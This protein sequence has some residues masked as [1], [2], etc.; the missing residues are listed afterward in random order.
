MAVEVILSAVV[1]GR[2]VEES[3]CLSVIPIARARDQSRTTPAAHALPLDSTT[4]R[5]QNQPRSALHTRAR[6]ELATPQC[7]E[8]Q[9]TVPP[10]VQHTRA[11]YCTYTGDETRSPTFGLFYYRSFSCLLRPHNFSRPSFGHISNACTLQTHRVH[12]RASGARA[13]PHAAPRRLSYIPIFVEA[14]NSALLCA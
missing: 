10:L 5:A 1:D 12:P 14:R 11:H 2:V 3:D 8:K 13:L 6:R 9:S 7:A 4:R